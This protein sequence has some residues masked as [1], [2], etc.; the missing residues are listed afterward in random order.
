VPDISAA[1]PKCGDESLGDLGSDVRS[2][3]PEG[4]NKSV[5]EER[6]G[7][8]GKNAAHPD[9]CNHEPG[10]CGPDRP[11]EIDVDGTELGG[12]GDLAARY[13][14]G[15]DGLVGGDTQDRAGADDEGKGQKQCWRHSTAIV[16][17]ARIDVPTTRPV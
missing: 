12:R 2:R 11:G 8:E 13:K 14:F 16:S 6:R 1:S 10:D 7:I 4:N 5:E 17:T 9:V 15:D 3:P